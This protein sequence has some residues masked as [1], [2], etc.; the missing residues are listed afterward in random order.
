M[1]TAAPLQFHPSMALMSNA[2]AATAAGGGGGGPPPVFTSGQQQ[3]EAV[4]AHQQNLLYMARSAAAA[5]AAGGVRTVAQGQGGQP[6]QAQQGMPHQLVS[7]I[8]AGSLAVSEM[9][10]HNTR[11]L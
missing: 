2:S 7:Q 10:V 3:Q 6:G 9:L 5:A 1:A 8:P 11:I 4:V